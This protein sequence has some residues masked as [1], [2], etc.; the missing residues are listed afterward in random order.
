[1]TL[2]DIRLAK[3][4]AAALRMLD[5]KIER[6]VRRTPPAAKTYSGG[7]IAP[8][9]AAA[10]LAASTNYTVSSIAIADPGFKYTIEVEAGLFLQ[11][12][13]GTTPGASHSIACRVDSTTPLGPADTPAPDLVGAQYVGT[14]GGGFAGPTMHRRS[15][16]VWSGAHTVYFLLKM[17]GLSGAVTPASYASRSDYHFDITI[18]PSG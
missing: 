6:N 11:G 15:P 5:N 17:G 16:T 4:P 1:M 14:L 9:N 18:H 8:F 13:S 12:L 10:T 3:D 7:P 2:D